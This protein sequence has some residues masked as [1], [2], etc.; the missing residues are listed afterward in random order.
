MKK[1]LLEKYA[2]LLVCTGVAI[3]KGQLLVIWA[4]VEQYAFVRLIEEEAYRAGAG[5]VHVNW[6]DD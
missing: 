1:E 4:P 5:S 3:Q 2:R 6:E